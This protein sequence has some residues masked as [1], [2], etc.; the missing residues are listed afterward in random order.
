MGERVVESGI[1]IT[2][3]PN[4]P[5]AVMVCDDS[6][7][8]ALALVAH[9]DDPDQRNMVLVWRGVEYAALGAPNDEAIS[10]HPLWQAGLGDVRWLGLVEKSRRIRALAAQNSVHPS[11]DPR[12]YDF[13]DH[14]IAPLKE[15]A[16]EVVARSLETHRLSGPTT[17]AAVAALSP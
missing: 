4:A 12:R 9:R 5:N 14:Y 10:G 6:G 2:W 8:T 3:E 15:C 1:R 7:Q 17:E 16:A 11:H 13:L